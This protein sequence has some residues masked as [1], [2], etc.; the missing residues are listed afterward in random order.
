M[1]TVAGRLLSSSSFLKLILPLRRNIWNKQAAYFFVRIF[2]R[3]KKILAIDFQHFSQMF[4][5]CNTIIHFLPPVSF[6]ISVPLKT[7]ENQR[8]SDLLRGYRKRPVA[9]NRKLISCLVAKLYADTQIFRI[10]KEVWKFSLIYKC[11]IALTHFRLM[12]QGYRMSH[13]H[14]S[15]SGGHMV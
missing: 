4:Y 6:Y 8:S 9:W 10:D 13:M 1:E 11:F 5:S 3:Q 12:F 7:S 2:K 15:G 14:L